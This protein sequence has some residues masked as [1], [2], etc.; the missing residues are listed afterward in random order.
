MILFSHEGHL[1]RVQP[2]E[3][4]HS[5]LLNNVTPITG[6]TCHVPQRYGHHSREVNRCS[7][8]TEVKKAIEETGRLRHD[9]LRDRK[10]HNRTD[11][12]MRINKYGK[13][14]K[15]NKCSYL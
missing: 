6:C 10:D 5:N 1:L 13:Q 7:K 8:L 15:L 11:I 9:Q 12:R 4:K 14:I 3:S 2:S